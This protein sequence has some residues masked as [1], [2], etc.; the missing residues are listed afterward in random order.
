MLKNLFT[1]FSL[2]KWLAIAAVVALGIGT[3]LHNKEAIDLKN[4]T[5]EQ[6]NETIKQKDN[7]ITDLKATND[8][9]SDVI[10]KQNLANEAGEKKQEALQ[11]GLDQVAG[12]QTAIQKRVQEKIKEIDRK[13]ET[14]EKNPVNDRLKRDELSLERLKGIWRTY[15]IEDPKAAECADLK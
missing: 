2:W 5:I 1:G 8:Q 15:C 11:E 14:L 6:K 13:Y 9:K 3:L 4:Q 10:L 7:K 12:K